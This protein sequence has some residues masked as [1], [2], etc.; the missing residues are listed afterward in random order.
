MAQAALEKDDYDKLKVVANM[1]TMSEKL[2]DLAAEIGDDPGDGVGTA[3]ESL[4][5]ALSM[6]ETMKG[7][8]KHVAED[9]FAPSDQVLQA[10]TLRCGREQTCCAFF[11]RARRILLAGI[12]WS[13]Q[14]WRS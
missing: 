6:A 13:W 9:P 2:E 8:E 3:L 4:K 12:H 7:G 10:C 14:T 11:T 5:K 1:R